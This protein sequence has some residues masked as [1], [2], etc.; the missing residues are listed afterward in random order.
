MAGEPPVWLAV[1]SLRGCSELDGARLQIH[2][3]G[4]IHAVI[5]TAMQGACCRCRSARLLQAR[6]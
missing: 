6:K 3:S 4:A 2:S 1:H 5:V